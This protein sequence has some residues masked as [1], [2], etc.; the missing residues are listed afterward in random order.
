[1]R[2]KIKIV[3]AI[4]QDTD[5]KLTLI[6]LVVDKTLTV[7][8]CKEACLP[9]S[10]KSGKTVNVFSFTRTLHTLTFPMAST[11]GKLLS[12]SLQSFFLESNTALYVWC[13][14]SPKKFLNSQN[15]HTIFPGHVKSGKLAQLPEEGNNYLACEPLFVFMILS[16]SVECRTPLECLLCTRYSIRHQGWKGHGPLPVRFTMR[17]DDRHQI[18]TLDPSAQ[19][20]QEGMTLGKE[21]VSC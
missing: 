14:L 21:V 19:V 6:L 5:G 1:M 8:V 2:D 4:P 15:Y 13:F 3:K 17:K 11:S 9:Y 10:S 12:Q 18:E 20:P 7:D 16:S